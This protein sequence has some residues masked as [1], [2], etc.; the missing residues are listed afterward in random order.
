MLCRF[1]INCS[2]THTQYSS[3]THTEQHTDNLITISL[4]LQSV[5]SLSLQ[6]ISLN[7][8]NILYRGQFSSV[9]DEAKLLDGLRGKSIPGIE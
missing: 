7:S 2:V 6:S 5:P 4:Y 8:Q 9:A 3:F 1:P